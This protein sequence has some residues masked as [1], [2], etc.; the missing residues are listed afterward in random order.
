MPKP[1]FHPETDTDK[2]HR[3]LRHKVAPSVPN[4]SPIQLPKQV[5]NQ[6]GKADNLVS[7]PGF[8]ATGF[9]AGLQLQ[10]ALC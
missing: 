2:V 6:L 8:I 3:Q 10:A 9:P 7:R 1:L 5:A 4:Q